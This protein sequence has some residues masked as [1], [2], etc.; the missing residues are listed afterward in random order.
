MIFTLHVMISLFKSRK[1]RLMA[2]YKRVDLG[3]RLKILTIKLKR[4]I[5]LRFL[6]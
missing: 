1:I 6:L 4:N 3:G 2:L 5:T